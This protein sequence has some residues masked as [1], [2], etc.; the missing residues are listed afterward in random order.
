[1]NGPSIGFGGG[2]WIALSRDESKRM[3]QAPEFPAV[4]RLW[5]LA[6]S[7]IN[8]I[9]HAQFD[10]GEIGRILATVDTDT[11]EVRPLKPSRV[12]NVIR[13]AKG[14]GLVGED[15]SARC[16]VLP[17]WQAQNGK[18]AATCREHGV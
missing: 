18:G 9:G 12:S 4:I 13:E 10:R 16:I 8:R 5:W 11:G 2:H 17:P 7:R 15:S 3:A 14:H 1:M 6:L